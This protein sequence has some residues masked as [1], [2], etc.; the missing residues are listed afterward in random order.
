M[1]N[2]KKIRNPF[3]VAIILQFI[4][5]IFETIDALDKEMRTFAHGDI[6]PDNLMFKI[7]H[8]KRI[9]ECHLIDYGTAGTDE[10]SK[11]SSRYG[12]TVMYLAP[13][14][15]QGSIQSVPPPNLAVILEILNLRIGEGRKFRYFNWNGRPDGFFDDSK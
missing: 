12:A 7:N 15:I 9:V 4:G 8:K 5:T 2:S 14:R 6:K 11:N 3:P 13:N 1:S 10:I